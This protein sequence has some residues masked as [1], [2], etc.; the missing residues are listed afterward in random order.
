MHLTAHPH[1]EAFHYLKKAH[2]DQWVKEGEEVVWLTLKMKTRQ[3]P[4]WETKWKY[5]EEWQRGVLI[6][7][8]SRYYN[9]VVH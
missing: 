1:I 5:I 8:T 4:L 9:L 2:A 6:A 3:D 7:T